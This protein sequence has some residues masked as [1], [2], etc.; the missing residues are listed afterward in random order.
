M[1][2]PG[3]SPIGVKGS[4]PSPLVRPATVDM[5]AALLV[6]GGLFGLTQV[7]VGDFVVTGSLPAKGPILGVAAVLYAASVV[8]GVLIRTGRGWLAALNLAGLFAIA[9][10]LAL[11]S[12]IAAALGFAHLGAVVVLLRTRRWFGITAETRA[13]GRS[14]VAGPDSQSTGALSK[15]SGGRRR[16][17]RTR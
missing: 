15:P 6:F 4:A 16:S 9:Y 11:P 3:E 17:P 1:T 14:T 10:L 7:A 8:L 5:V 2:R 13:S 12:P